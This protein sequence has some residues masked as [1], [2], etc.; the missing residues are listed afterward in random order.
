[1]LGLGEVDPKAPNLLHILVSIDFGKLSFP[2][3]REMPF[4][5]NLTTLFYAIL[6]RIVTYLR[7]IAEADCVRLQHST[8]DWPESQSL[9]V[10]GSQLRL[11]IVPEKAKVSF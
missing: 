4:T 6:E 1:M 8:S 7:W 2:D 10:L 9:N 11:T 3:C 5:N